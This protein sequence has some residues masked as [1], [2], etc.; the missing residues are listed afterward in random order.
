MSRSGYN[1]DCDDQWGLIRW[2]GAVAS[3]I[4]GKRGQALLVELRDAM[5]AMPVKELI[6][7]ELIAEGSFC[8]L[9]VVG[10]AR[11]ISLAEI[12][13]EDSADVALQ[14]DIAEPLAK[15]IVFMNDEAGWHDETP[16]N[17]WVRMRQWVEQ[18][19][20]NGGAA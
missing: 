13:P 2:R 3:S 18:H 12:N 15:E 9:G 20:N 11:G 7:H 14:F 17:R 5:D 8:A 6:A 4:R 19:V 16:K 10:Q 1:D